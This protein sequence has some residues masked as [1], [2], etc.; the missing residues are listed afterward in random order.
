MSIDTAILN[1]IKHSPIRNYIVPGLTSWLITELSDK[2]CIRL[3]ESQRT[4]LE[5][6]I[7]H[8]HRFDFTCVVIRGEVINTIYERP[9]AGH[10]DEQ[11]DQKYAEIILENK[12]M[13][14]SYGA[15]AP[16]NWPIHCY[17]PYSASYKSG[18]TYSMTAE[19]IHSIQFCKDTM[20]LFFEGPKKKRNICYIATSG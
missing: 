4:H 20:V 7:P 1:S 19:Q 15:L 9:S 18:E 11:K 16:Q 13:P 5:R 2:G 10:E 6:I 3:F 17:R 14:G 8:S 12:G